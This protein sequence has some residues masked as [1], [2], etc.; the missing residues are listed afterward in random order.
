MKTLIK[1]ACVVSVDPD[2]GTL[3]NGDIL[4][5]DGVIA[6]VAPGIE[7]EA[8][9]RID[10]AGCIAIPGL[11][12]AHRHLWEG[13]IRAVTADYSILD[14]IGDVRLFGAKFFR[15]EDMYATSLQGGLECLNAGVTTVADYCHNART[16][17][18]ALESI[19]GV[20]E[21]GL[22]VDWSFSFTAL[23]S[24][25]GGF[26]GFEQRAAFFEELAEREFAAPGLVTLGL[27][28]EESSLWRDL[29]VIRAQFDLG[30]RFGARISMHANSGKKRDGTNARDVDKLD[31][32]GV[33]G[34]DLL[35]VHMGYTTDEE[36][37]RLGETGAHVAFS[38]ETELQMGLNWPSIAT[39]REAGVNIGIG[40]DITANH[41]GDMFN[42]LRL[43]LQT[44][45]CRLMV[46]PGRS[47]RSRTPLSCADA[48]YWGTL[49]G[50]KALGLDHRIGSLTPGKAADI[51]LLRA[52]DI[53]TVGWDRSNPAA[54]VIQQAGVCNVETV[55]VDGTVMKRNGRLTGDAAGAC[56]L[57]QSTAD[58]VHAAAR[59][60]GGFGAAQDVMYARLGIA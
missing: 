52:D 2:I 24:E 28:P 30:R 25:Q 11:V 29:A 39:A 46:E 38:P 16:P 12:D 47:F 51:V 50:A 13:G 49:G 57:L 23:G 36:W 7:A 48:L 35:L 15:P 9:E 8:A 42:Q 17:A 43:A 20:R 22:R 32:M 53:T 55:L 27:C 18:H 60:E 6:A 58:H 14:F 3:G 31:E 21:A 40:V 44:Q 56:R 45:R 26:T 1:N 59:A 10:G 41:S 4:I 54:T 5:D 33:L 19:R 34:P 37:R